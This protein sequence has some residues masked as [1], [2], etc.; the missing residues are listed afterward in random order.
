MTIMFYWENSISLCCPSFCTQGQICLLI[1]VFLDFLYCIPAHYNEKYIFLG[2]LV[3]KGLVGLHAAATAA[4]SFQSC[5]T[6]RDPID[7]SP[8]GSPLPGILQ[9]EHW[10]GLTFPSPVH[11][12]EK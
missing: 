2:V 1:Q 6:L 12:S 5:Q 8:P 10:S 3:L 11:E 9:A 7:G 4:K